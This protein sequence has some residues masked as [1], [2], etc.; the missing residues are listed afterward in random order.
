ME[1]RLEDLGLLRGDLLRVE[2]VD[3]SE[4]PVGNPGTAQLARRTSYGLF[5]GLQ[6]SFGFPCLVT[7]TTVD[8]DVQGQNGYTI[9]P[10]GCIRDLQ[11]IKRT[12]RTRKRKD[13]TGPR[14][15]G[16]KPSERVAAE[17]PQFALAIGVSDTAPRR[18]P[19]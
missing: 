18:Q 5:W 4:D 2:W 8:H 6:E 15:A 16:E 3:I 12:R 13:S 11:V 9:Y 10:L 19:S 1:K 14:S 17:L 7:T